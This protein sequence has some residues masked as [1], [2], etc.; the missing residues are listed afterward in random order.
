[1]AVSALPLLQASRQGKKDE[2]TK[3]REAEDLRRAIVGVRKTLLGQVDSAGDLYSADP[4]IDVGL[5]GLAPHLHHWHQID[6]NHPGWSDQLLPRQ[7]RAV[8][9]GQL[10]LQQFHLH[11]FL[12]GCTGQVASHICKRAAGEMDIDLAFGI[13]CSASSPVPSS[14]AWSSWWKGSSCC[15]CSPWGSRGMVSSPF[16]LSTTGLPWP[17]A[18][19]AGW[20]SG[21]NNDNRGVGILEARLLAGRATHSQARARKLG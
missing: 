4:S 6:T 9:P 3:V 12:A 19:E 20:R 16:Y 13:R 15:Q 21:R 11:R 1:M 2:E 8:L 10:G 14:G 7:G 18:R 5:I 17:G